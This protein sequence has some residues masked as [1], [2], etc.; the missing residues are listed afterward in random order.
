MKRTFHQNRHA[1]HG[2]T[3]VVDTAGDAVYVG[4][5][6]DIVEEGVILLQGAVHREGE[7]GLSKQEYL[8]RAAALGVWKAFDRLVLPL[9]E[10]R[11]IR[12]LSE[13]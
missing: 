12:R 5:C 10:V 13:Y 9:D 2:I 6:D 7:D 1:L 3:V 11:E 4:R 8:R